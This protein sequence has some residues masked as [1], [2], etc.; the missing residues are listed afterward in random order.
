MIASGAAAGGAPVIPS[1]LWGGRFQAVAAG[2]AR[3]H[4]GRARSACA[5]KVDDLADQGIGPI[6]RRHR[7]QPVTKRPRA[8][9]QRAVAL[10]QPVHVGAPMTAPLEADHV[11]ADEL[12]LGT[13]SKSE[14]NDVPGYSAQTADHGAFADTHEL[15]DG[16]LSAQ[17]RAIPDADMTAQ[18]RVVGERDVV[19]DMAVM[20]DMGADH[21]EATVA[22]RGDPA[23]VLGAGAHGDALADLA[24]GPDFEPGWTAAVFDRLRR[25][26]ERSER[27]DDGARAN[28]GVAREMDMGQETAAVGDRHIGTDNAI[29]PDRY[30]LTDARPRLDPRT[31]IDRRHRRAH[32][33]M[34]PTLASATSR[35]ATRALP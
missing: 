15:V 28:F 33:S 2:D 11:Q 13:E 9:E 29:G 20:A 12:G 6:V 17:E 22:D 5:Q 31:W 26:S 35:P 1:L 18:D 19:A 25:G 10:P 27:I 4:H 21:E 7:R 3:R 30:A 34:A 8:Q 14:R 16:S 23:V 32:D 24:V